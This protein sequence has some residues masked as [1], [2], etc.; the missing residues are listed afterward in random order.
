[1][2]GSFGLMAALVGLAGGVPS[3]PEAGGRRSHWR[4]YGY[5]T[6]YMRQPKNGPVVSGPRRT[7]KAAVG[8]LCDPRTLGKHKQHLSRLQDSQR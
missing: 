5:R 6:G 4:R 8:K 3:P 7:C 1:M 2:H